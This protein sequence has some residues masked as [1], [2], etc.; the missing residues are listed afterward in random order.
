MPRQAHFHSPWSAAAAGLLLAF[1]LCLAT[2]LHAQTPSASA[3]SQLSAEQV[4]TNKKALGQTAAAGWLLLLDAGDWGGSWERASPSFRSLVPL[5]QW[6]DGVPQLRKPFGR[7]VARS[8]VESNHKTSLPGRP[9][10]DYV[11]SRFSTDF[12]DKKGVNEVVTTMLDPDG[13]WRVIGY[14]AQ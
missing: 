5:P 9:P 8:F 7:F 6:M 1:S 4:L 3:P 2:P 10:G 13:R 11:S 14:F 12:S